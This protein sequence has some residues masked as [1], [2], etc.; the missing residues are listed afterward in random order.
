MR[1]FAIKTIDPK[2]IHAFGLIFQELQASLLDVFNVFR[3]F[4]RKL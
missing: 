4:V 2:V 3:L 1:S